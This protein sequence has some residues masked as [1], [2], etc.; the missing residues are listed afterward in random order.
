MSC[1]GGCFITGLTPGAF[2]RF[3]KNKI[4]EIQTDVMKLIWDKYLEMYDKSVL[5]YACNVKFFKAFHQE[6][7]ETAFKC[8]PFPSSMLA[9]CESNNYLKL[10]AWVL[11]NDMSLCSSDELFRYYKVMIN[12]QIGTTEHVT[13]LETVFRLYFNNKKNK[14]L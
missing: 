7:Q 2:E 14:K 5:M 12:K 4:P 6:H 8:C 10:Y 1:G 13:F 3:V 9:Y 11:K